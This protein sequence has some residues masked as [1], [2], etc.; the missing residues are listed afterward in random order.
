MNID[1]QLND[2]DSVPIGAHNLHVYHTPGHTPDQICIAVE[3]DERIIVG[4]TIFDGGPG[5]TWSP[6]DF[7]T[8]LKT[9]RKVIMPWPNETR[10][11]PGHGNSFRLGD[12]RNDI[13]AFLSK[14][15][16]DFFG[17]ATWSM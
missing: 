15:H 17:D 5:K 12:I 4:D 6:Q 11:Y 7:Q 8:T 3:A 2:G 1:R 16:G 14:N 9:L 13:E 10:C